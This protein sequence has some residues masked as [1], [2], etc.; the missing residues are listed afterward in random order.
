MSDL[1]ELRLDLLKLDES[2]LTGFKQRAHLVSEIQKLKKNLA[3]NAWDPRQEFHK[4]QKLIDMHPSMTFLA[5]YS[6]LLES[7]IPSELNYPAWSKF[8]HLSETSGELRDFVN[9]I[10]LF[11]VNKSE[12][13]LLKLKS[14][15]KKIISELS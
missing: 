4:F 7:H 5:A 9:P 6:M 10:L 12:Y 14:E 2:L 11:V 13:S 8:E 15:Y 1:N 3:S